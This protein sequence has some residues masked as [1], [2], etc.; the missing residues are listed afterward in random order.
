MFFKNLIVAVKTILTHFYRQS[1]LDYKDTPFFFCN[2]DSKDILLAF[3][4]LYGKCSEFIAPNSDISCTKTTDKI[5][6]VYCYSY[7]YSYSRGQIKKS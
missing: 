3:I 5:P 6:S 1:S 2:L 4:E 7:I